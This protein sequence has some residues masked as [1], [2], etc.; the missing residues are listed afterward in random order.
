[1]IAEKITVVMDGARAFH[2]ILF[3]DQQMLGE[4]PNIFFFGGREGFLCC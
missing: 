4:T 3:A 1:M 2:V